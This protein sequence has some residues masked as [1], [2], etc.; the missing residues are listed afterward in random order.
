MRW[1]RGEQGYVCEAAISLEEG[2]GSS[3]AAGPLF[4]KVISNGPTMLTLSFREEDL[5]LGEDF[6]IWPYLMDSGKALFVVDGV[7]EQTM[8]EAVSQSHEGVWET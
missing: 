5:E 8:G 6:F 2:A 4:A 1:R 7:A 3:P